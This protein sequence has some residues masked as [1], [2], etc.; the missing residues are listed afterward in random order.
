VAS[1]VRTVTRQRRNL[2]WLQR[3]AAAREDEGRR[4]PGAVM[5]AD[6]RGVRGWVIGR[7]WHNKP[8]VGRLL[9]RIDRHL[10]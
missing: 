10:P 1:L 2:F 6:V 3:R 8:V 9:R 7:E 4:S 5:R